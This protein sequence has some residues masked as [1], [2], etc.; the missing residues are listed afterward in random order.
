MPENALPPI[1]LKRPHPVKQSQRLTKEMRAIGRTKLEELQ[2]EIY[3]DEDVVRTGFLPPDTFLPE[4]VIKVVLDRFALI[5]TMRQLEDTTAAY[6]YLRP[7]Q[8]KLWDLIQ[9]LA[10]TFSELRA[11][12]KKRKK[13]A[14]FDLEEDNLLDKEIAPAGVEGIAATTSSTTSTLYQSLIFDLN[15]IFFILTV[16]HIVN[17]IRLLCL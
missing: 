4:E 3:F 9:Q 2:W 13:T 8:S 12:K 15:L 16:K 14:V 7:H 6:I 11:A 5:N 1:K 10:I 17:R